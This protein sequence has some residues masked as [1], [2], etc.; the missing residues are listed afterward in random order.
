MSSTHPFD[1]S[2]KT[3]LVTGAGG[4]IGSAIATALSASGAFIAAA[5]V[6]TSAAQQCSDR[7]R[8]AGGDAMV[9]TVDVTEPESIERMTEEVVTQCHDVDIL[10]NAAGIV[11][12]TPS[13]KMA[14]E[15]WRRVIDI[16]LNGVFWCCQAVGSRMLYQQHTGSI[17]NIASISGSIVNRPQPQSHYN[18]SKAGVIMLTRSLAAE[19]A[20]RGVRVNA[21]SPGYTRTELTEKGLSIPE[22]RRTWMEMTPMARVGEPDEI[23]YAV[24]YLASDAASFTTGANLTLDGG[25]TVW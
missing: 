10:I 4:G 1:L 22:W 15:E 2:G 24:V 19:W 17:I 14:A 21:V 13:E 3:A 6:N 25:Y 7:V 12:N 23:A 9:V 18:A 8:K 5:D 20:D 11:C 16:N